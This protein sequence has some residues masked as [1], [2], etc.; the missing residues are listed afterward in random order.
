MNKIYTSIAVFAVVATAALGFG[1]DAGLNPGQNPMV[2]GMA[3]YPNKSIVENAVNSPEHT[4][5]VAAVPLVVPGIGAGFSRDDLRAFHVGLVEPD[6]PDVHARAFVDQGDKGSAQ[7]VFDRERND[8][9]QQDEKQKQK[10]GNAQRGQ[11]LAAAG[12]EVAVSAGVAI[13]APAELARWSG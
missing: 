7:P 12:G 1:Q 4:T 8:R 10:E 9:L 11:Q 13:N 2:G 6:V 3:M 5:L